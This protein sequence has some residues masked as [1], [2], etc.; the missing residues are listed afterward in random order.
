[1]ECG[2]KGV[3]IFEVSS[4]R[5]TLCFHSKESI[6]NDRA[7][8]VNVFIIGALEFSAPLRRNDGNDAE[9]GKRRDDLIG[10]LGSVSENTAGV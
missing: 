4:G 2:D 1:M 10:I 9:R 3:N 8:W 5:G 7:V 6:F